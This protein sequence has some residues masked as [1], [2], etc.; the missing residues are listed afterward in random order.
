[1]KFYAKA[2]DFYM[3][4]QTIAIL[5]KMYNFTLKLV[6]SMFPFDNDMI[7]YLTI[8]GYTYTTDMYFKYW[9]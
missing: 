8:M 4:L 7:Q 9:L 5:T 6:V 3:Y 2:V 1:M